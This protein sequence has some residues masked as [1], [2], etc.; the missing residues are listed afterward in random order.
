MTPNRASAPTRRLLVEERRRL[1]VEYVEKQGRAT[2]EELARQFSTSAVTIRNDLE[3]LARTSAIARSHGG[4]LPATAPNAHDTPLNIKETRHHAQKLRIGQAAARLIQNGETVILDSGSTT[5]EIARQIRQQKFESLT[6]ITNALN[7][8][9]ELSGLSNI[10]V[11]MLGGLLRETSYSLVGPDAEQALAKLSADKLFLGVDGL[12]P[13]V[14]VTTPDP[15]E[16]SLNAL[17]IRVSRETIAVF[18]ASKLG[19]RSLS[20]ITPVQQ[21]HRVITDNS[22]EPKAVEALRAAGVEVMLV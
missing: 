22:A 12:D 21:L 17:M 20:V 4:A 9:L 19:Q 8:A 7:I 1:I 15:L 13:V 16:A 2:V 14:G 11:M 18:D 10:R 6:V 3:S 5:V